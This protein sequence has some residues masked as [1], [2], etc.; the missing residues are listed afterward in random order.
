[1]NDRAGS[2]RLG[3][4][5][6]CSVFA[7][8]AVACGGAPP[9]PPLVT[10]QAPPPAPPVALAAVTDVAEVAE[11]SHVIGVMRWK[12]PKD[13][14]D[15]IYQW[16]G[17]HLNPSD[18]ASDP[19]EKKLAE[20]AN[21]DAP[22]D[23]VVALD[24]KSNSLDKEPMAALSIGVRSLEEVRKAGLAAGVLTELRPGE[25]KLAPKKAK[26][27]RSYCVLRAAV[28]VAPARVVCG[29][30]ERDIEALLPYMTR[31]LPKRDLGPSDVHLEF[32]MPPVLDMYGPTIQQG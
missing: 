11:P 17:V 20:M 6:W 15:I 1:M 32:R 3:R 12:S 24:P 23:L 10:T 9:P 14:L 28:G 19:L 31:T 29:H 5:A 8:F 26:R 27:D 25:Y 18:L 2:N 13:T 21:T 16:V 22:V 4:A 30:H 7:T